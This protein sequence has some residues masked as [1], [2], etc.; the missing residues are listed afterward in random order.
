MYYNVLITEHTGPPCLHGLARLSDIAASV[1]P[2][3]LLKT[4]CCAW[5][6]APSAWL[7]FTGD[8]HAMGVQMH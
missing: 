6:V 5:S 3:V 7:V 8:L 4:L 1:K 2:C